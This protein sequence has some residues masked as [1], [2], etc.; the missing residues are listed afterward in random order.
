M[1]QFG[2][3]RRSQLMAEFQRRGMKPPEAPLIAPSTDLGD[4]P[5]VSWQQQARK[6]TILHEMQRRGI[7]PP[8]YDYPDQSSGMIG[9]PDAQAPARVPSTDPRVAAAMRNQI[10]TS[11]DAGAG[12]YGRIGAVGGEGVNKALEHISAFGSGVAE[13]IPGLG[14]VV[15]GKR[16]LP[17]WL[18]SIGYQP[19]PENALSKAAGFDP[20]LASA[21][22]QVASQANFPEQVV[23][24]LLSLPAQ[25]ADP[26]A[27]YANISGGV[28]AG[29]IGR[30]AKSMLA[31]VAAKYGPKVAEAIASI[32]ESAGGVGTFSG[33][34]ALKEGQGLGE[35]AQAAGKG[36]LVGGL[37]FGLPMAGAKLA[38]G[39]FRAGAEAIRPEMRPGAEGLAGA[40]DRDIASTPVFRNDVEQS[41][42]PVSS[43][44]DTADPAVRITTEPFGPIPDFG[45]VRLGEIQEQ[46]KNP[47]LSR[48]Q[49]VALGN[50][51]VG[52]QARLE[53][54]GQNPSIEPNA[55]IGPSM[56]VQAEELTN[57][58]NMP[59]RPMGAEPPRSQ[60]PQGRKIVM[61]AKE[62]LAQMSPEQR[63]SVMA[64]AKA[65]PHENASLLLEASRDLDP[66][67]GRKVDAPT[68][69]LLR[70]MNDRA[71]YTPEAF[72]HGTGLDN[73]I[74]IAT[75]G[76][77][78]NIAHGGTG[79]FGAKV[80]KDGT[81]PGTRGYQGTGAGLGQAPVVIE[82]G[83]GVKG[84]PGEQLGEYMLQGSGPGARL[85]PED[86]TAYTVAGKRY[87]PEAFRE[88]YAPKAKIEA[89]APVRAKRAAPSVD[90]ATEQ[91]RTHLA[92]NPEAGP[93]EIQRELG[94]SYGTAHRTLT[95]LRSETTRPEAQGETPTTSGPPPV[96]DKAGGGGGVV[97]P[98]L[99]TPSPVA[100]HPLQGIIDGAETATHKQLR[101]VA[102]ELGLPTKG[103]TAALR[104][105]VI[106]A[107][108]ASKPPS[109]TPTTPSPDVQQPKKE[110]PPPKAD[111]PPPE[112]KTAPAK[113]NVPLE[114]QT[115]LDGQIRG[116]TK[117]DAMD[118]ALLD[119]TAEEHQ[120]L[121]KRFGEHTTVGKEI[122][123]ALERQADSD[124]GGAMAGS[125]NTTPGTATSP[126]KAAAVN[127]RQARA[128]A[129]P[130]SPHR[131]I[132]TLMKSLGLSS[133]G[134]GGAR[135][136]KTWAG[137]FI[138]AQPESIRL[139]MA[140][141]LGTS[142]HEVGHYL[143]KLIFQGGITEMDL[144][145]KGKRLSATGLVHDAFPRAWNPE[146]KAMGEALYGKR[147]PAAGY[148]N[149]G[150]AELIRHAFIGDL[151]R[152]F[153]INGK[154]VKV[155][156]MRSYQ[157]AISGL[158]I[159]WPEQY[160]AL[161]KFRDSY[162]TWEAS[163]PTTK[164]ALY[165]R[166]QA[167][168][169]PLAERLGRVWDN[170]KVAWFDRMNALVRMKDDL[171]LKDLPADK[172]PEFVARRA[173]GRASGDMRNAL[174]K[175]IF[176][177]MRPGVRTGPSL[178]ER[179]QPVS[180][181]LDE[182]NLYLFAK[183]V[184]ER[185]SRGFKGIA[186]GL[187]DAEVSGVIRQLEAQFP[188]FKK[189][190]ADFYQFGDWTLDYAQAHGLITP[191]AR[192]ALAKGSHDYVTLKLIYDDWE[193]QGR[194]GASNK[195]SE[196]GSGIKRFTKNA[197]GRQYEPP[198]DSFL[199]H[200]QGIFSRAQNNRVGQSLVDLFAGPADFRTMARS[201]LEDV[202]MEN[203]IDPTL[204]RDGIVNALNSL[205]KRV[206]VSEGMGRWID[207]VDRPMEAASVG[208]EEAQRIINKRLEDAGLD[209]EDPGVQALVQIIASDDFTQ[210][211]PTRKVD[212]KTRQFTVLQ[213][214]KPTYWEAKDPGLYR[215]IKGLENPAAI[216]G[217][218]SLLTVPRRVLR[219]GAT[220]FNPIFPLSNFARDTFEMLVTTGAKEP[221]G[222][223]GKAHVYGAKL[224]AYKTAFLNGD[225]GAMFLAS[226]ADMKGLFHD[227]FDKE[228]S[229]F[230]FSRM[231]E[232]PGLHRIFKGETVLAKLGDVATTR[233]A[234][235]LI[236][237]LNERFELATR[238]AE[239]E[240]HLAASDVARAADL[241]GVAKPTKAQIEAHAKTRRRA[242]IEAAGQAAS[243]VTLDFVRGG[244]YSL[245]VNQ[246]IPFFN[247][248]MQGGSKLVR[249]I[250]QDPARA[251]AQIM[252]W[253]VGP[254]II[255]HVFN[256]NDK[257]YWNR[258]QEERD[259]KWFFPISGWDGQ[260]EKQ[261][262]A[263]PK[264]YGLGVFGV[265]AERALAQLDGIDPAT[266]KRGAKDAY[267]G[268]GQAVWSAFRPPVNIPVITPMLELYANR[269]FY[270]G[271]EIVRQ[272][273]Q[274][275]PKA[276]QGAA[277][278]S[279][280]A[281]TMALF[282]QG[283]PVEPA[284]PQI[285]YLVQGM[286]G[287]AGTE[288]AT[289]LV[290]PMVRATREDMLGLDPRPST[291]PDNRP[292]N[293]NIAEKAL[294]PVLKGFIFGV[295]KT[296]TQN[297]NSF[298]ELFNDS[299]SIYRGMKSHENDRDGGD[300]YYRDNAAKID[301]YHT[302][303]AFKTPIDKL[304]AEYRRLV[305]DTK[306][307]ETERNARTTKITSEINSLAAEAVS[308]IYRERKET[309]K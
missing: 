65:S 52:I 206:S 55:G 1:T 2:D 244:K 18:S 190:A 148:I 273:E 100:P 272:G 296:Y 166:K 171:D 242:D 96:S 129:S 264:P 105:R 32:L 23:G 180:A 250:R 131:I 176:D 285:D 292:A 46:I 21:T 239:F 280:F 213:N 88:K 142:I 28:A 40:L 13:A 33:T 125:P 236:E 298:R 143:Q 228:T 62:R 146:L 293:L 269:S 284:P 218:L 203:G 288:A 221:E 24:G 69:E 231:F 75:E 188:K 268:L 266:G 168:K 172:D 141:A 58:A 224:K 106:E 72:V 187:G 300:R 7:A 201:R 84:V 259:R 155:E 258:P 274:V 79:F 301:A 193:N 49:Q 261:Y 302:L 186:P 19:T 70:G 179:I 45:A 249:Y 25:I 64:A 56:A 252:K 279:E 9:L 237:K 132:G 202:A 245:E 199:T 104:A 57:P 102:K 265:M 297:L 185:R 30:G 26:E 189:A 87:T 182:F 114:R 150:W 156:D 307:S 116:A 128:V 6:Q 205:G 11:G 262:L 281:K 15:T 226:G 289:Y 204:A 22:Q 43:A 240:S 306:L 151:D 8:Q 291:K 85:S 214:G 92:K 111:L 286:L 103:T 66:A 61:Q 229:R 27:A 223:A 163:S 94:L 299:Q 238:L 123:A 275:G 290:D 183:R 277:R 82:F 232:R 5:A 135:M 208:S 282:M 233:P 216:Q 91:V 137:G 144:T 74:R 195:Y 53:T 225:P 112:N 4:M 51:G 147:K 154:M 39:L 200:M 47:A 140:D 165:I 117:P 119:T 127:A 139:R 86:V 97:Q 48:E 305:S 153:E 177:P 99:E 109:E 98:A 219:A 197:M 122:R 115:E 230:D 287:K 303:V 36:A 196:T 71:K 235:R 159:H 270:T 209:P 34:Q 304:F 251:A 16:G 130:E 35:A 54:T 160:K 3:D 212:E 118:E 20:S 184:A 210:F 12:S 60:T 173:F 234:W 207:K 124:A 169:G 77:K 254:S 121:L 162:Q 167:P 198:L 278:S 257:D 243:D 93:R 37:G 241:E 50:E 120:Y 276:E 152:Q 211:R 136:L 42:T 294:W 255:Q 126:L 44:M 81:D 267:K 248:A 31:P 29:A 194:G 108:D 17:D 263:I 145:P 215:F 295:P 83:S 283:W 161:E 133:P 138:R 192:D 68:A 67:P 181:N 247:A 178:S 309:S 134:V 158:Q 222:L 90:A 76:G 149:E 95:R 10:A 63:D 256:R 220:T 164:L 110:L 89:E 260:E 157:E 175:G 14:D 73:A 78:D 38:P 101:E 113:T 217:Y 80:L 191:E 41:Y 170:T 308:E 59:A 246:F 107:R 253:V 271:A 174:E 227:Y